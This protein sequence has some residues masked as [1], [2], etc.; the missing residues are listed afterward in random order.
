MSSEFNFFFTKD[1][2]CWLIRE[3]NN[4]HNSGWDYADTENKCDKKINLPQALHVLG[5]AT[6]PSG[7]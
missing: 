2:F 1:I 5:Q 3:G 4:I 7:E 6:R